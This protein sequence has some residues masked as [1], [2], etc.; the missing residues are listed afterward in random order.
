MDWTVN[1]GL[2][3]RFLKWKSKCKNIFECE[4]AMLAEERKCK[5]IIAWF[6]DF[7][8]DQSVSW[9]LTN[10]E[11]TLDVIWEKFEEFCKFQSNE[12]R[13][14]FDLLTCFRQ[15]ER[16]VDEWY[17]TVQTQVTLAKYPQEKQKFYIEIYFGFSLEMRNLYQKP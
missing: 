5:K 2:Y 1:D 15:G 13:A 6:G 9:D 3:N 7:G 4:L 16:S 8:I 11:L 14:R 17:N 12:V 10:D